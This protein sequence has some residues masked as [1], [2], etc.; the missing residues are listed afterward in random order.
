MIIVIISCV[1]ITLVSVWFDFHI[2]SRLLAGLTDSEAIAEN[3]T[4][5]FIELHLTTF[6]YFTVCVC[7]LL[8]ASPSSE[9]EAE[10]IK[11]RLAQEEAEAM[12]MEDEEN[13]AENANNDKEVCEES[14]YQAE[15]LKTIG[16]T[17]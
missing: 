11:E 5:P 16:V 1:A 17:N 15:H 4:P 6:S 2:V 12:E 14:S 10:K 9:K 13:K 3:M 7:V 8:F